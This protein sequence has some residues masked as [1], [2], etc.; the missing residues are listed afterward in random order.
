[1]YRRKRVKRFQNLNIPEGDV[2]SRERASRATVWSRA[3]LQQGLDGVSLDAG[4][5]GDY[6]LGYAVAAAQGE[7]C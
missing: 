3:R 4:D 1:M 6:H 5:G 7:G 2:Q